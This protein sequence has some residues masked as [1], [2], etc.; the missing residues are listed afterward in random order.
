MSEEYK[1]KDRDALIAAM[2][3]IDPDRLRQL[4]RVVSGVTRC[5]A[6]DAANPPEA[7][8]CNKCGE[9]LYPI[10]EAEERLFKG[11]GEEEDEDAPR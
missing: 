1:P 9:K 2:Y 4:R 10:E 3:R 8:F 11:K 7:R 5:P 6:C